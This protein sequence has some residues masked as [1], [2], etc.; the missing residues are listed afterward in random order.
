MSPGPRWSPMGDRV[1]DA[2]LL[3]MIVMILGS[4]G[5]LV[6]TLINRWPW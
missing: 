3:L 2:V 6:W 5:Y 1:M 4:G